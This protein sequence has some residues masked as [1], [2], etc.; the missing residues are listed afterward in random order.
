MVVFIR[1]IDNICNVNNIIA[2]VWLANECIKLT[3]LNGYAGCT[4]RRIGSN[5][6]THKI[7]Y[8]VVKVGEKKFKIR[9]KSLFWFRGKIKQEEVPREAFGETLYKN[10][11][12]YDDVKKKA[13]LIAASSI[14]ENIF[15]L[16]HKYVKCIPHH[17][18][19][20][21]HN[22]IRYLHKSI[23][24]Y[25][26]YVINSKF[27]L[28]RTL[29]SEKIEYAY[30]TYTHPQKQLF[31]NISSPIASI[32]ITAGLLRLVLNIDRKCGKKQR[33]VI[34]ATIK[35]SSIFLKNNIISH[36]III[37]IQR[38]ITLAPQL[39]AALKKQNINERIHYILYQPKIQIDKLNRRKLGAIK[40]RV[41][42]SR[43]YRGD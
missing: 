19:T 14:N 38:N 32:V 29:Y 2:S 30:A 35:F 26:T 12:K 5:P 1:Y 23:L 33:N 6:I 22:A 4:L 34:A 10:I 11:I 42:K 3:I 9:R 28:Y 41:L 25:Y 13:I 15:F 7:Q 16:I 18:S 8:N 21:V 43:K 40:K 31:V 36:P 37:K 39:F 20:D 27:I 24:Y 17:S